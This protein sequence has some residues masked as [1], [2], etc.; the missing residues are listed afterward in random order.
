MATVKR[1]AGDYSI[2]NVNPVDNVYIDTNTL[3]VN[4]NVRIT[5]NLH[6]IGNLTEIEVSQ[7][8]IS[9]P[10]I[11]VG[12]GNNGDYTA[13]GIEVVKNSTSK[14]GL[15]WNTVEDRWELSKDNINWYPIASGAAFSLFSDPNPTLSAPLIA[16]GQQITTNA[17]DLLLSSATNEVQV[18]TALKLPL[19]AQAN[20]ESGYTKL[21]AQ[22]VGKGGTGLY[23]ASKDSYDDEVRDELIS[24]S[25][26]IIYSIIF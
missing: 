9:D 2:R 5:G 16:T 12:A 10:V 11:T 13:L 22:D 23:V 8:V 24:R 15:R 26:A 4:G 7:T 1:I 17:G 6:V 20:S 25:K 14:A 19:A 3:G 21:Y 18:D